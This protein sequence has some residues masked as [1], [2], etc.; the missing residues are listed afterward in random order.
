MR[1]CSV[2]LEE[3]VLQTDWVVPTHQPITVPKPKV[4][5]V[6]ELCHCVVHDLDLPNDCPM[7]LAENLTRIHFLRIRKESVDLVWA[8]KSQTSNH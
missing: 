2:R 3:E 6:V 8:E 1:C 7:L 4:K 5:E